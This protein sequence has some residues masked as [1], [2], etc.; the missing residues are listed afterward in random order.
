M[1]RKRIQHIT[2]TG[3]GKT[4]YKKVMQR[5]KQ[6][7]Y[8]EDHHIKL[9]NNDEVQDTLKWVKKHIKRSFKK[10]QLA[11]WVGDFL[12]VIEQLIL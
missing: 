1:S 7:K 9:A 12:N 3:D 6:V 8:L 5:Q 4:D 2:K 11:T 10:D